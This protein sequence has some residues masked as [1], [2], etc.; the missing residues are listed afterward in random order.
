MAALRQTGG[1]WGLASG[2]R[3]RT[4]SS[5]SCFF[6]K[7]WIRGGEGHHLCLKLWPIRPR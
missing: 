7:A 5:L 4:G 1:A 6:G 2:G 3:G